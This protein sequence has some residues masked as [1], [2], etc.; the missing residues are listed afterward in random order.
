MNLVDLII[1][2]NESLDPAA[3]ES[4]ELDLRKQNGVIAPRFNRQTSHLLLIAYNPQEVASQTLLNRV[5][6]H[7][8]TAQLVGI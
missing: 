2:V 3:R 1:H 6:A 5:A 7:G 8:Y 4:L